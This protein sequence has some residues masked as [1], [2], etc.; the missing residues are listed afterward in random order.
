MQIDALQER[1]F[2]EQLCPVI[3]AAGDERL[4]ITGQTMM[5][6]AYPADPLKLERLNSS[7]ETMSI[8]A[9]VTVL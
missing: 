5:D 3:N 7:L 9:G 6:A 8:T 2:P 1:L 4:L